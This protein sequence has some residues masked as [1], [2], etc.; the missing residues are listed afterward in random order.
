MKKI[1]LGALLLVSCFAFGQKVKIKKNIVFVDNKEWLFAEKDNVSDYSIYD[2][3][4][5]EII[6]IKYIIQDLTSNM[7]FNN[8]SNN[9]NY[10]RVKFIGTDKTI[11]IRQ[12]PEDILK[13]IY[14]ANIF[15]SDFS[16]N[17]DKLNILVDKYGND[18]SKRIKNNNQTVIIQESRPRNGFN[19]S[20]G[21]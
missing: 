14:K 11:E 5:N 21:R 20:L 12:L 13:V 15:N 1:L 6:F 16:F 18:F 2:N 19:I 8:D 7:I 10:F 4:K 17:L 3:N 9:P